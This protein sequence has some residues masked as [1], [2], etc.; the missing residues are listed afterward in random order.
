MVKNLQ[1]L[2]FVDVFISKGRSANPN[3]KMHWQSFLK[4]SGFVWIWFYPSS[5]E[6]EAIMWPI[7]RSEFKTR[8]LGYNVSKRDKSTF[9]T[10]A[11]RILS[12]QVGN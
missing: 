2:T 3:Y 7:G 10:S 6:S 1:S 8:S 12:V 11:P 5:F 4:A 9:F